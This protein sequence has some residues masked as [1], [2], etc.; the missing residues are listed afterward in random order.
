MFLIFLNTDSRNPTIIFRAPCASQVYV[1]RYKTWNISRDT[2][3]AI[4]IIPISL[5]A[6]SRSLRPSV[7]IIFP[8]VPHAYTAALEKLRLQ[9]LR[10]RSH[11]IDALFLFRSIVALNAAL[12]FWKILA[13]V[14]LPAILE[15]SHCL[16]FVPLI[17]TV[18]LL[19]APVLP[20]RFLSITFTLISLNS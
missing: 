6:S 19:G 13:F 18:L 9:S 3:K 14:F 20:T 12:P 4:I 2:G 8:H 17:N 11:D 7:F 15:T 16:V 10:K 5:S 1:L